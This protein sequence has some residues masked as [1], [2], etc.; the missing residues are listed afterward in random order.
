VDASD[1]FVHASRRIIEF[2]EFADGGIS[3]WEVSTVMGFDGLAGIHTFYFMA[4]KN[5]DATPTSLA[6]HPSMIVACFR[7]GGI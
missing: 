2:E 4:N 5:E 7:R 1:D 3:R 6:F